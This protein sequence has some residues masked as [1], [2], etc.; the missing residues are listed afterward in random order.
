MRP[1]ERGISPTLPVPIECFV[2]TTNRQLKACHISFPTSSWNFLSIER[3]G[4]NIN[5]GGRSG[6]P[7][8]VAILHGV[9]PVIPRNRAVC[10][11]FKLS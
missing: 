8:R 4:Q 3:T 7:P 1:T 5:H 2:I 6:V 9:I 10:T 11:F